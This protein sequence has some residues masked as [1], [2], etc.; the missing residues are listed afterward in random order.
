M[1]IFRQK[2]IIIIR[3][4]IQNKYYKQTIY[5]IL[6][7]NNYYCTKLYLIISR[8]NKICEHFVDVELLEFREKYKYE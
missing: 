1:L 2:N 3:G 5:L 7:I 6:D 4:K 8:W